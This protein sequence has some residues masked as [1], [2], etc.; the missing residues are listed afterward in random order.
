MRNQIDKVA[1]IHIRDK[2]LLCTRTE[3]KSLFYLPGG[4]RESGETDQQVLAREMKE[5]IGVDIIPSSIKFLNAF[6]AQADKKPEGVMVRAACYTA[7]FS[8]TPAA[9]SEIREI[10]WLSYQDT[11]KMTPLGKAV[12]AWLRVRGML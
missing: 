4:K 7:D 5:E 8:G 10:A 9:A 11:D 12:F 2:K 1:L 3:G 6:E